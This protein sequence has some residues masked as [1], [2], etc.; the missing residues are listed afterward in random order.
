MGQT[1]RR[2]EEYE[3]WKKLQTPIMESLKFEGTEVKA[4]DFEDSLW[5]CYLEWKCPRFLVEID[6]EDVESIE[7]VD[8]FRVDIEDLAL[9]ELDPEGGEGAYTS[10]YTQDIETVKKVCY[11]LSRGEKDTALSLLEPN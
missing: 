5:G 2:L 11:H 1:L 3:R 4:R 10:G 7:E 6:V 8:F 9:L